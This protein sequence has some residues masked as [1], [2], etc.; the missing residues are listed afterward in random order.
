MPFRSI[1]MA[2]VL[3]IAVIAGGARPLAQGPSPLPAPLDSYVKAQLKLGAGIRNRI[4]GRR[5]QPP[6]SLS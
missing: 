2:A 6:G 1:H 4:P 3:V 5:Q